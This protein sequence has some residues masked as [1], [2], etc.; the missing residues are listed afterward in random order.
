[1]ADEYEV[2][3]ADSFAA[4]ALAVNAPADFV[5]LLAYIDHPTREGHALIARE[6]GLFFGA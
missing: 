5:P 3:L 6:L 2:G 1:L 4:F